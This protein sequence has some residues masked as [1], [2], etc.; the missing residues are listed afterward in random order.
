MIFLVIFGIVI[1]IVD[2]YYYQRFLSSKGIGLFSIVPFD[3][4]FEYVS[5][6]PGNI[7]TILGILPWILLLSYLYLSEYISNMFNKNRL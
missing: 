4:L 7:L 6:Y 5:S 2:F 3:I 1:D